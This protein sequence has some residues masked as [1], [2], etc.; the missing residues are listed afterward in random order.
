MDIF[1]IDMCGMVQAM[2]QGIKSEDSESF[3]VVKQYGSNNTRY[4]NEP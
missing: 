2:R 3:E 4:E 1:D